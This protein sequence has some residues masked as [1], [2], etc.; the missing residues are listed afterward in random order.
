LEGDLR[1]HI[2][3]KNLSGSLQQKNV[4]LGMVP[5]WG[6]NGRRGTGF[7]VFVGKGWSDGPP[8]GRLGGNTPTE[9]QKIERGGEAAQFGRENGGVGSLRALPRDE[10]YTLSVGVLGWGGC[11]IGEGATVKDS[12]WEA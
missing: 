3:N 4:T 9:E 11:Y 5:S 8:A 12:P 1:R 6:K 2:D 7:G 10:M